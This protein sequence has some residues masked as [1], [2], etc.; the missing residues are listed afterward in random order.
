MTL[1]WFPTPTKASGGTLRSLINTDAVKRLKRDI[2]EI[3]TAVY[4]GYASPQATEIDWKL[5]GLKETK[6]DT[7][8]HPNPPISGNIFKCLVQETGKVSIKRF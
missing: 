8:T 6:K 2:C 7:V 5:G 4:A 1:I 3:P